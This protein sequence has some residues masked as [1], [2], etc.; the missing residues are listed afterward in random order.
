MK[1][2]P[3]VGKY[4]VQNKEKYVA[5]L[6]ECEYRSSWELKYMK[7]LDRQPNVLEWASENV[8]IPYYN[9]VEKKTRR[10]FVDFYVKVRT[11]EGFIKKYIIEIKPLNQCYPPKKHKRTSNGYRSALKAYIRFQCKWKAAKKWAE[12]RGW[13]FI[14]ITEKELG[15]K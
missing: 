2:Y 15:I 5:D 7:Y 9:P 11:T 3:R 12:K 4:R 8:I 6:Q 14:V 1:N 13:E 10:Y